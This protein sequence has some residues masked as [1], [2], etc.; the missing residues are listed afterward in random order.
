MQLPTLCRSRHTDA[1]RKATRDCIGITRRGLYS[2][3]EDIDR[4]LEIVRPLTRLAHK[5]SVGHITPSGILSHG[6]TL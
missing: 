6:L 2:V 4:W 3:S 1:I 5:Q